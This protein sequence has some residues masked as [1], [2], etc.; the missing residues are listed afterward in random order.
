MVLPLASVWPVS[1]K[2]SVRARQCL[3]HEE[4]WRVSAAS[5]EKRGRAFLRKVGREGTRSYT[6]TRAAFHARE[7]HKKGIT[8][9]PVRRILSTRTNTHG[10]II[11]KTEEK[12]S[13]S[14]TGVD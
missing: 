8:F 2:L 4:K 7:I 3:G 9:V 14:R 10:G 6:R 5:R 13:L 12:S 11:G 1:R